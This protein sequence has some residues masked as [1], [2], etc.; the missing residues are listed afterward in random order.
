MN[1]KRQLVSVAVAVLAI[2]LFAGKAG[3]QTVKKGGVSG[4][5]VST[6]A[7]KNTTA[8]QVP[9]GKAYVLTEFCSEDLRAVTLTATNG[10]TVP[11]AVDPV[12]CAT[13]SPGVAFVGP[14]TISC[15]AS[16]VVQFGTGCLITGVLANQ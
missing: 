14:T 4:T 9:A 2:G 15:T 13:Y 16:G 3:A 11:Q 12:S 5:L 6:F 10:P 7:A 8:L 1:G